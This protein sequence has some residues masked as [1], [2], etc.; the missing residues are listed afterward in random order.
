M[1]KI[2]DSIG[3][4]FPWFSQICRFGTVGLTAASIHFSIVVTLVQANMFVPLVANVF[5]FLVSFQ[6]SYWGH[7]LWTFHDAVVLHRVAF[8]RLLCVQVISLAAN[9]SLFYIFLSLHL[10]YPIALLIVLT[11]IPIFTFLSSKLW[12]F[13]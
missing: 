4:Y 2:I 6:I 5:G 1:K 7:R 11:I 13:R 8:L 9:E 3:I 12:V 10:P